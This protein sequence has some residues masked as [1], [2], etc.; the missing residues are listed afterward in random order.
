MLIRQL[1]KLPLPQTEGFMASIARVMDVAIAIPDFSC[2]SKRTVDLSV[3][4]LT[5]A[6]MPAAWSS[7]TAQ[8]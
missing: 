1:F 5:K 7:S 4:L 6:M 2:I 3:I 8:D